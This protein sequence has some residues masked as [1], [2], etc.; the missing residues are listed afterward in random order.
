[1]S[2]KPSDRLSD[3][4]FEPLLVLKD[5]ICVARLKESEEHYLEKLILMG[6]DIK[7]M[8]SWQ[9]GGLEPKDDMRR[10]ELQALARQ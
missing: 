8:E 3:W 1:M 9:N 7:R 5:H 2:N 6:D 10:G 4:F